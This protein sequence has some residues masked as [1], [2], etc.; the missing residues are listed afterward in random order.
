MTI[1]KGAN[2]GTIPVITLVAYTAQL[3]LTKG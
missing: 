3:K 1:F 2:N